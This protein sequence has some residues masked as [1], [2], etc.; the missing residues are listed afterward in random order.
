MLHKLP[1]APAF[2]PTQRASETKF[3]TQITASGVRFRLWAPQSERIGLRLEDENVA[4]PM[5]HQPRGWFELEVEGIG[6]GTHY[7]F[8][9]EDGTLVPDPASRFQPQDVLGPSEVIDPRRYPWCDL[10]W[11]GRPWEEAVLY[12]LHVGTFTPEGSFAAAAQKLDYLAALGV[13]AIE[14]MPV[15]D[16][17][18]R[19]NWGYD[20]ALQFAPD[21]SYGRPDDL[22]AL[23][24]AAHARHLMVLLDVVY[25]HF[26]P[27]GNFLPHDAPVL[28]DRHE[29]PWGS[30]MNFDGP[31]S[32]MVRDFI[33]ANARYWLNE[34]H[35]D[36]LRLDAVHEIRDEGFNHLLHDLALQ[37]RGSTDGRYV[38]LVV[39]DEE[40][41]PEW[42]RRTGDLRAGLYDAQWNDDVHHLIDVAL[43]GD[44]SSYYDD[45][46]ARPDWLPRALASGFGFQGE[47]VATR[48]GAPKGAPSGELPPTAFVSFIQNHDQ[49]GNRLFGERIAALAPVHKLRAVAAVYLLAPQVPLLFMGEEWGTKRPFLFFSDVDPE[50]ADAIRANRRDLFGRF[51][52]PAKRGREA[53]DAMAAATF[54]ASKLDWAELAMPEHGALLDFYTALLALRQAEIVPRLAGVGGHAGAYEMGGNG[55]QF[56]LCWGLNDGSRLTLVANLTDAPADGLVLPAGRELWLEGGTAGAWLAPWSVRWSLRAPEIGA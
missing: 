53:P 11:G 41:D 12:E 52:L 29:T 16:F 24:D 28:T 9:L 13:T 47:P 21:S 5:R 36:G 23:I 27:K 43:Y 40:N 7:R 50:F 6:A 15:N 22:K 51:V 19:W 35:F 30:A 55:G 10:G 39:E 56:C 38:H 18:G 45:Y 33:L 44:A 46:A 14:L 34:Y 20:G 1:A 8:E 2:L 48:G 37:I 3:G 25:N 49:V 54:A 42:L 26:G 31:G 32:E 17:P 4:R